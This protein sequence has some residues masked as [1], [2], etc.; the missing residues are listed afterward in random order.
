MEP[1]TNPNLRML[2]ETQLPAVIKSVAQDLKEK[3]TIELQGFHLLQKK[4]LEMGA[5][6]GL[7]TELQTFAFLLAR[8]PG[9]WATLFLNEKIHCAERTIELG[10]HIYAFYQEMHHLL[11]KSPKH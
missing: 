11:S 4:M 9:I 7:V 5:T 6:S 8:F 1:I 2:L 3:R 10:N